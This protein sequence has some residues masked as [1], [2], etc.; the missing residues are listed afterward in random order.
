M[1]DFE[2][3]QRLKKHISRCVFSFFRLCLVSLFFGSFVVIVLVVGLAAII[4]EWTDKWSHSCMVLER[5]KKW[6]FLHCCCF[7]NGYQLSLRVISWNVEWYSEGKYSSP[8]WL[9]LPST[10]LGWGHEIITVYHL[11]CFCCR[12][13]YHC[14]CPL[15]YCFMSHGQSIHKILDQL[16]SIPTNL[17][18][19]VLR[20][21]WLYTIKNNGFFGIQRELLWLNLIFLYGS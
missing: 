18:V 19:D 10:L 13:V 12:Q 9:F 6:L 5:T 21:L 15:W 11:R 7:Q 3:C 8:F 20:Q 14:L 17:N 1:F 4:V 16:K 2:R